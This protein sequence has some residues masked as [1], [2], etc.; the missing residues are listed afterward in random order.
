MQGRETMRNSSGLNYKSDA[1]GE[2]VAS[3]QLRLLAELA[4]ALW[5]KRTYKPWSHV[6]KPPADTPQ[7]TAMLISLLNEF[8][9]INALMHE[10][11]GDFKEP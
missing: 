2:E 1:P 6:T 11:A 4:T 10:H 7:A 3:S 8:A 5:T 9:K